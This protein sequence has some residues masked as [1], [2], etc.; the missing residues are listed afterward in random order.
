MDNDAKPT[1]SNAPR[2][3]SRQRVWANSPA[4]HLAAQRAAEK[5]LAARRAAPRCGAARKSDGKPC[6]RPALK[7]RTRC[8]LHGGASGRGDQWHVVQ[9]PGPDAPPEAIERKMR[10]LA[11]REQRRLARVAAMT[12]EQ[13]EIYEKRRRAVQP[14]SVTIR[15]QER[16]SRQAAALLGAA[17]PAKENV[18]LAHLRAEYERLQG[19]LACLDAEIAASSGAEHD[20]SER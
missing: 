7:G 13:R 12:P 15:E 9:W 17:K 3:M 11:R 16:R 18:E 5:S 19:E 14:R 4:G 2:A 6:Q 20:E 1:P 10:D 8:R